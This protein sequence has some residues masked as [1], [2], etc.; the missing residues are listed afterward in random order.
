MVSG[1][2]VHVAPEKR[3]I[4]YVAQ[5]GALFPIFRSATTSS[6]ACPGPS[7]AGR[8]GSEALLDSV[9]LPGSYA[10]RAPHQL[11][12]GD[13]APALARALAPSPNWFCS[14]SLLL[15]R[16]RSEGR[17]PPGGFGRARRLRR[18]GPVT[19]DHPEALVHGPE[20]A[21]LWGGAGADRLAGILYRLPADIAMARFV[22]E[23]VILPG[24]PV[25]GRRGDLPAPGRVRSRVPRRTASRGAER[26]CRSCA[27]QIRF[28]SKP[29]ADVPRARSSWRSHRTATTATRFFSNWKRGRRKVMS[30]VPLLYRA[31]SRSWR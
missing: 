9:D 7:A 28:L 12:G 30:L 17:N 20:V 29:D 15:A 21:V 23:A 13:S 16:R 6:L 11:S 18:D 22:G 26:E 24:T 10:S 25:K 27:K 2:G 19:H 14:T 5:E 31:P 8:P 4:G 3:R 1:P